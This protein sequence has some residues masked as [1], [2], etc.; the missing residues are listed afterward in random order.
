STGT[1]RPSIS[2]H[3]PFSISVSLSR[4]LSQLEIENYYDM[5]DYDLGRSTYESTSIFSTTTT[6]S[7]LESSCTVTYLPMSSFLMTF[8]L[9]H[10]VVPL[11]KR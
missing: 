2:F 4:F 11:G 6:S 5:V 10:D 8:S 3:F 1:I 7:S 9:S